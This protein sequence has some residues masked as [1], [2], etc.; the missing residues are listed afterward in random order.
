METPE[1]RYIAVGEAEI[2]YQVVGN[3]PLDLLHCY[4]FGDI[5]LNWDFPSWIDCYGR[6]ASF[7]RL[8]FFDRRGVGISDPM[9]HDAMPTWEEWTE[10][11]RAVLDVV[12]SERA[13][14]FAEND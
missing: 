11:V 2:A 12:G 4:G 9:P 13:A 7:C 1:T 14:I 10:D 3:G 5:D 8:I 6:L